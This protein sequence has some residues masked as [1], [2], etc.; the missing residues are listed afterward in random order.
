MKLSHVLTLAISFL[1]VEIKAGQVPVVDGI[2]GGSGHGGAGSVASR[3]LLASDSTSANIQ[4]VPGQLRGVVEN[5]GVCGEYHLLTPHVSCSLADLDLLYSETT[6]GVYQASGYGD[7]GQD[8]SIWYVTGRHITT[9][10]ER[11]LSGSGFLPLATILIR[12][13]LRSGLMA[14]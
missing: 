4:R 1:T 13:L 8:G 3:I 9:L 14:V 10:H 7:I 2:L 12:L 5:S 11:P 6:S